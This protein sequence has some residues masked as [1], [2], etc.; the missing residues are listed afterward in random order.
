VERVLDELRRR[1]TRGDRHL[2]AD[3]ILPIEE[4]PD[5]RLDLN[6]LATRCNTCHNARTMRQ[7]NQ[8]ATSYHALQRRG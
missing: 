5:L 2:H 8:R 6:N 3:H 1:Y 7:A 4:Q